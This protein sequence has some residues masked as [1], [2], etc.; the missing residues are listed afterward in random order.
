MAYNKKKLGDHVFTTL[1]DRI[2][3][4]EYAPET[5]LSEQD[6]CKEFKVSRTPLRDALRRLGEMNLVRA[7][8][9]YGTYV[10]PID[11]NE[12][13]CAFEVK[14]KLEALCGALAAR[15]ISLDKLDELQR[16][17]S[18]AADHLS[19]G[20]HTELI[21][22]DARFHE[23]IYASAQNPILQEFL[24]NLHSRCARLW[25]ANLSQVISP[26]DIVS[27]LE[28]IYQALQSHDEAQAAILLEEHVQ[29]FIDKL[30]DR[31]L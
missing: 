19:N 29:F 2:V 9:R 23:I 25:G 1:R 10:S 14:K 24:V 28:N 12:I 17:I 5:L 30:K 20:R 8:P 11:I 22:L 4:L 13:R 16:L 15:R 21:D 6:L 18:H 26:D 27:Q 7:I 3:Q 31:L